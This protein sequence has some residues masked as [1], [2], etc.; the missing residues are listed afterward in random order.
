M[1]KIFLPYTVVRNNSIKLAHKIY[2]DGFIPDIIYVSL[3][4]GAYVGNVISEYF[5]I[6]LK[7]KK[8]VLYAAVSSH[9]YK[10]IM[11]NSNSIKIDGWTYQGNSTYFFS[12][13]LWKNHPKTPKKR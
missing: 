8:P 3:R 10:G 5:K 13:K 6:V 7:N 4:G 2:G 9:S 11:D 12:S 1:K